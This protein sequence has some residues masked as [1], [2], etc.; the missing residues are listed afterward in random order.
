MR[1]AVQVIQRGGWDLAYCDDGTIFRRQSSEPPGPVYQWVPL[2]V[3][4]IEQDHEP[5]VREIETEGSVITTT[6]RYD[7]DYQIDR[8]R[9]PNWLNISYKGDKH[10]DRGS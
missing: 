7:S 10:R 5:E 9:A 6:V 8:V 4:P 1:K 2:G 3:S